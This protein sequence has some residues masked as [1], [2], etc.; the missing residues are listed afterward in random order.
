MKQP[1]PFPVFLRFI[2]I[3]LCTLSLSN[4]GYAQCQDINAVIT[5]TVPAVDPVDS[6]IKICQGQTV[7]FIGNATF[8]TTADG[9]TYTWKFGDGSTASGTSASYTYND[10][11]VYVVDFIA[12][13]SSGCKSKNCGTRLV[14][15]VSTTPSFDGTGGP[16]EMCLH[17][18]AVLKGVVTPTPASYEC[19]PPVSDTTFLP[20]GTGVS[21]ETSIE[22]ECFTPC[23]TI[24]SADQISS[25]CL[26]MEHSYIGDLIT[27]ITCPSGLSTLL[28]DGN[29]NSHLST[30]LGEPN[31]PG[32]GDMIPGVGYDYCFSMSASW[33]DINEENDD[34][35]WVLGVGDPASNSMT[36]GSYQ[37]EES[38]ASLIG[39][40]LN[41]TWTI[42]VTDDQGS[43]NG[44]IFS[45][46]VNFN[47]DLYPPDYSFTPEYDSRVWTGP[48]II[49]PDGSDAIIMPTTGGVNC[50]T[51][52]VTDKF[53]CPYDTTVCVNV[54]DPGNPGRDS[55]AFVCENMG[56]INVF[57]YLGGTP[58]LGGTWS[59]PGVSVIGIFNPEAAGPGTYD[60]TYTKTTPEGCDTSATVTLTV[61]SALVMDFSYDLHKGCMADTV[62]F[63]NLTNEVSFRWNFDDGSPYDS[64]VNPTHVYTEQG[65][66]DVWLI[67][68]NSN[69]CTDSMQKIIDT[70]HP[71]DAAFT[72]SGDSVC[73][74]ME[75]GVTFNDNSVGNIQ[76]WQWDFGDG[77]TSS[78]Q[79]PTHYYTLAG[80]HQVRLVITDDVPCSD[81]TYGTVYVDSIPFLTLAADADSICNG[82]R[83]NFEL[84]YLYTATG[85]IWDF[86]DNT[87]L[88]HLGNTTFHSYDVPGTY[89]V[90][91]SVMQPVCEGLTQ[92]LSIVVKPYPIVNL[93]S[94]TFICPNGTPVG[95][96][97][98]NF[99][100]DP[101]EIK[102]LWNTG[103]TSPI[104]R[105]VEPGIYRLT[106]DL[107]GCKTTDEIAVKK[108]CYTDIP[109]SFT[110]NGDGINDYFYP[111]QLL[112]RG[113]SSFSM[114]VFDRWGQKIFATTAIDG[115]GWD[116]K[117]N[118][119]DQ[120]V[121]VYIYQ[122]NATFKDGG[123]ENHTGNVTLL[124]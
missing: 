78:D 62:V 84:D 50:Y 43:D 94:D 98:K 13:D 74:A 25:I 86:G 68:T 109:N 95:L 73:Q 49:A 65:V 10:G 121:G 37:P 56:G 18:Q 93:G 41:G 99:L 8:E 67:A 48:G 15:Q 87:G 14:I 33:G 96:S 122:I 64:T 46:G 1:L 16:A 116:G 77:T 3:A 47:P 57:D 83:I 81:T 38:Y 107:N 106:A 22:V 28:F 89:V 39:C 31:D 4:F 29:N 35:N 44:Y 6:V 102:W 90:N 12:M 117:F 26:N 115:R 34:M 5:S 55:S 71:L 103:S 9:A 52:T 36:S 51:F 100:T 110:P 45:W 82:D 124:R 69:V 32:A 85:V 92:N 72:Q 101:D 70:R 91:V 104:L 30:Y 80:T 21:Y 105:V 123:T 11:G 119:Q 66:Y 42:T 54:I 2:L 114:T 79:N 53:N 59:G 7:S 24:S 75:N 20:D 23:D 88:N 111:R 17:D 112:S 97:S 61:D 108:D 60:F 27:T 63:N 113:V 40:P 19:A 76:N 58:E 120:P 118:D